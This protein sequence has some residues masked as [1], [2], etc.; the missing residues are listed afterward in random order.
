MKA[1]IL[2][3]PFTVFGFN[4]QDEG[5]GCFDKMHLVIGDATDFF[6]KTLMTD[7]SDLKAVNN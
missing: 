1:P 2:S 3:S 7:C 4:V 6:G 5:Y